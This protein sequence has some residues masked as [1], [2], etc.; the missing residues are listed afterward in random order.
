[1]TE[2]GQELLTALAMAG[3]VCV[4]LVFLLA[5]MQKAAHWRL[6]PGVIANYRLLPAALAVPVAMVLPP[7]ELAVGLLLLSAQLRPFAELAAIVL[8]MLF[9]AA[10]AI[11]LRRGRAAIDCGCGRPF[12]KQTLRWSLVTRNAA[13]AALLLLSFARLT[14]VSMP[15]LLT[16][17]GAGLC[18]VLLYS[19][20]NTLAA[21]PAKTA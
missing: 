4:G 8:L 14:I 15:L 2:L 12:L 9:A 10:M 21:L 1:M 7:L 3:R 19:L 13:L 5:A 11:N 16:G 18:F 20:H 6:L 17:A